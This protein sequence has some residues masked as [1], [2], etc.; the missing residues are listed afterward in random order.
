M[1][2]VCTHIWFVVDHLVS[3]LQHTFHHSNHPY[4]THYNIPR[5]ANILLFFSPYY[6]MHL[7]PI[8]TYIYTPRLFNVLSRCTQHAGV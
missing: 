1:Q 6:Y 3:N 5:A 7:I 8:D 4:F 2:L